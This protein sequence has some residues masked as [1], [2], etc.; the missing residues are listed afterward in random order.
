MAVIIQRQWRGF[1]VRLRVHNFYARKKYLKALE[2]K[3]ELVRR[4][5]QD[6]REETMLKVRFREREKYEGFLNR[7]ARDN[8][9]LVSTYT[10]PGVYNSPFREYPNEMELRLKA[11]FHL[12]YL[13]NKHRK[14]RRK[15]ILRP[16][17]EPY[18]PGT[19]PRDPR[20]PRGPFKP[21]HVIRRL[22]NRSIKPYFRL[23]DCDD[24]KAARDQW[25][26]N[27]KARHIHDK[28]FQSFYHF[29]EPYIGLV[30]TLSDYDVS[31][32]LFLRTEDPTKNIS[33]KPM[34][35][36]LSPMAFFGMLGDD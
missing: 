3:N 21:M 33:R 7:S 16:P 24:L 27:E 1:Y 9:H 25:K 11:L 12:D 20:Q 18:L 29:R 32:K 10:M 6:I 34:R 13:N 8:H 36:V 23:Y 2:I 26:S 4:D 31:N 19:P 35:T 17:S 14:P 15:V 22:R 28:P 30:H 5:L